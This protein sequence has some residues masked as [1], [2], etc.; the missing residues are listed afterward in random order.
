MYPI[1]RFDKERQATQRESRSGERAKPGN[2]SFSAK[3][4]IEITNN[5]NEIFP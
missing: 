3:Q 4:V 5:N 1:D 2:P